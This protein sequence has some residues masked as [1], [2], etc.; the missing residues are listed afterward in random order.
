MTYSG[1][2][3]GRFMETLKRLCAISTIAV[4]ARTF[5]PSEANSDFEL[6]E[7]VVAAESRFQIASGGSGVR[8][9]VLRAAGRTVHG[10]FETI[11]RD[12]YYCR[13]CEDIFSFRSKL[14]F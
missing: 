13:R 11:L 3:P 14:R 12:K 1:P 5:S 2:L 6:D 8:N 7:V 4:A 10:D 9:D